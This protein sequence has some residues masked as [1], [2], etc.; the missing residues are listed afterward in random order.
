VA[1]A[2]ATHNTIYGHA[3]L[4]V[5]GLESSRKLA[6][7]TLQHQVPTFSI[8]VRKFY[9]WTPFII[10][11]NERLAVQSQIFWNV[12]LLDEC[13]LLEKEIYRFGESQYENNSRFFTFHVEKNVSALL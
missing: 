10:N 5:A 1:P 2:V 9:Q 12:K 7:I 11:E 6:R 13:P 3:K 4:L 8:E